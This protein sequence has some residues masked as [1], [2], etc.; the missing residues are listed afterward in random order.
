MHELPEIKLHVTEY[1]LEKG[2]CVNC[3]RNHVANLPEGVTW[4][5][6]GPK[7]TAFM[8][9]LVAKYQLS[10]R[11][12]KEFLK[13][14]YH[15]D[16]SLGTVFNKQKI[17]TTALRTPV[18]ALLEP[19]KLS[20]NVNMDETSHTR[21]G[22]KEWM[23]SVVSKIAAYFAIVASRGKKALQSFMGDFNNIATS[24][25]YAAYNYF[26][27]S[28][29]QICWA[30]LKRDF[31]RLSEKYNKIVARIGKHL[32]I[33]ENDLFKCWYNF[34]ENRITRYE[35]QRETH[36][37][38]QR[39]GELLEQGSYTDP[40]LKVSRFCKNLLEI[41]NALWTFLYIEHVEPTNNNAER[42]L[43]HPVIWRKKYFGTRSN[44]GSEFVSLSMSTMMTC[45]LQSKNMFAYLS[46]TLKNHFLKL[47][48]PSLLSVN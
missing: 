9:L 8:S 42:C 48:A 10:R 36:P 45:K 35:L 30:H 13:E 7:L 37:I 44:Y 11:Q 31:T 47:P 39:I 46:E 25:R 34:K 6:T 38:R 14:Q 12:L 33:C 27:S 32:L 28:H 22:K 21:N 29:R 26:D 5:I 20:Q 24:D 2:C 1:L 19:I 16:L 43:R 4:G 17:V 3:N 41:F 15:F 40:T 23:W 18:S